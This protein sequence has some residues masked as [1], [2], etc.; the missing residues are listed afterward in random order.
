MTT[1]LKND[2]LL[3]NDD[4]LLWHIF[5]QLCIGSSTLSLFCWKHRPQFTIND[6]PNKYIIWKANYWAR[7]CQ[8]AILQPVLLPLSCRSRA[9]PLVSLP[10]LPTMKLNP[11]RNGLV[12]ILSSRGCG[13]SHLL[14]V[15]YRNECPGGQI[16]IL[17]TRKCL[18]MG[19]SREMAWVPH[20]YPPSTGSKW[21]G[22]KTKSWW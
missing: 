19:L 12:S 20:G 6:M 3:L 1:F 18:Q 16:T 2:D 5:S 13:V 17:L 22:Q 21:C 10:E 14:T 9:V 15:E 11:T 4:F 8:L 7:F